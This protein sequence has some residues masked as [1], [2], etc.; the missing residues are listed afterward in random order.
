[1]RSKEDISSELLLI[2]RAVERQSQE[3][4]RLR[5]LL[6]VPSNRKAM[7]V[8]TFLNTTQ[9]FCGISVMIMNAQ[10]ILEETGCT[11]PPRFA[12]LLFG[13]CMLLT[14]FLGSLFI[15]RY[16]LLSLIIIIKLSLASLDA[17]FYTTK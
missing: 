4:G 9:H 13:T 5:D 8:V 14:M 17:S 1:M 10:T 7:W 6:V 12:V 3:E 15:D 11:I 2:Q 16:F